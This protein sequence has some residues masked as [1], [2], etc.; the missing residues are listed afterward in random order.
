MVEVAWLWWNNGSVG[1]VSEGE[2]GDSA[3]CVIGGDEGDVGDGNYRNGNS[4]GIVLLM[5]DDCDL[6][7]LSL[8]VPN[9]SSTAL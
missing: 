5:G 1:G 3:G 8:N 4:D 7:P 9:A 6:E 2:G